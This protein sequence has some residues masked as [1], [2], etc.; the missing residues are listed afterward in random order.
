M[1]VAKPKWML[2]QDRIDKN[3]FTLDSLLTEL[4]ELIANTEHDLAAYKA[5]DVRC[6]CE[7]LRVD[8]NKLADMT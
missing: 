6:I 5:R 1:A 8:Y 7:S 2:I 4:T 3:E